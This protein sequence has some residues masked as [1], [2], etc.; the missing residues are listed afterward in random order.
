MPRPKNGLISLTRSM[1]REWGK[2]GIRVNT[3]IPGLVETE[4][5][6]HYEQNADIDRLAGSDIPLGRW[7]SVREIADPVVFLA[8]EGASYITGASILVDG[9][10]LA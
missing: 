2:Q 8:S 3:V 5:W 6:Q 9:G 10:A 4:A 7:A 1:A